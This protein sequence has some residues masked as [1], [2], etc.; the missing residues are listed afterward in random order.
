MTNMYNNKSFPEKIFSEDISDWVFLYF[1]EIFKEDFL[2]KLKE[3][4]LNIGCKSLFIKNIEPSDYKFF[5]ETTVINMPEELQQIVSLEQVTDYINAPMSFAQLAEE[6]I[7]YGNETPP[8]F[9]LYFIRNFSLAVL[10]AKEVNVKEKFKEFEI[11]DLREFLTMTFVERKPTEE[12]YK[13][14]KGKWNIK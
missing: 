6:G 4:C 8:V 7:I 10:G 5:E 9:C 1:D 13:I 12:F 2:S 14:V 11:P 3:F